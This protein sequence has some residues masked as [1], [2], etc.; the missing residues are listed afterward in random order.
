[1]KL[2]LFFSY[3]MSAA[4]WK[5]RGLL[6]R[7]KLIYEKLL[8]NNTAD[9]IYW[10]TYGP[11]DKSI[12]HELNNGIEI[13]PMPRLLSSNIGKLFYSFFLPVL[14][15]GVI[16]HADILKTNQMHG[17]WAAVIA[18]ILFTK[19]LVVRTGYTWS[20]FIEKR[21]P[22][23][24]K[25]V[26]AGLLEKLA[27]SFS[28]A[29]AVSSLNDLEFI[30]SRYSPKGR[31]LVIP[32]YIDTDLFRPL[33]GQKEHQSICFVGRLD[34]QKNLLS[35]LEAM[36]GLPYTLNI[37]G[38][39][40]EKAVLSRYAGK[41]NISVRFLEDIENS[42]LPDVLNRQEVFILP[43]LYEGA[44]KALLEAMACGLPCIGT[45]VDGI[46]GIIKHNEN[47]CLCSP[48]PGSIQSAIKEVFA[49]EALRRK[50]GLNAR[51]TVLE[52]YSLQS[53]VEKETALYHALLH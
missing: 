49:N 8:E 24:I 13:V 53:A 50:I 20:L 31:P 29:A 52:D 6:D 14:Q 16:K 19:K 25:S 27:Y 39:G 17:S 28:D 11:D 37:I 45:D 2:A 5:A 32:N 30:K 9:R 47:G 40:E 26:M 1:M 34:N 43:S 7:E 15:R 35:L 12:E 38:T 22:R 51:R 4:E 48:G 18:K 42:R 46:R 41:N 44:P 21:N 3:G 36:I 10:L 33:N 23:S